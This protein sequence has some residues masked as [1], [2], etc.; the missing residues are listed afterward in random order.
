MNMQKI[1][2]TGSYAF[3]ALLTIS[4]LC[5]YSCDPGQ[6]KKATGEKDKYIIPDTVMR[7]LRI[8]TVTT[9]QLVNA[10]TLTGKVGSNE[11]KVIPVYSMVSGNVQDIR[12]ALGDYVKEG[13][14]LALVRS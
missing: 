10:I 13:Q 14:V 5:L 4:M 2:R 11:D 12:V 8:D 6:E 3:G 1:F 9:S 7:T